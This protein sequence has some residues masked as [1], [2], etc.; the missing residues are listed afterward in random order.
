LRFRR[1]LQ[2]A[3]RSLRFGSIHVEAMPVM[4][5]DPEAWDIWLTGSIEEALEFQRP[6]SAERLE[7][8]SRN[9]RADAA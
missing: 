8:V 5:C 1:L 9:N 2:K 3:A 7:I 6:L 4:L